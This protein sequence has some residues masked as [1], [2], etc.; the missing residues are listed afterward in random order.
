MKKYFLIVFLFLPLMAWSNES[1][2]YHFSFVDGG[3]TYIFG[4]NVRVRQAP[5]I[6]DNNI[7]ETLPAGYPVKII[8]KTDKHMAQNGFREYW[9]RIGFNKNG[10][11]M[12]GY[13]WGGVIAAGHINTGKDLFL[14][15]FKKYED[16][17]GFSG[18]CRLIR[19]GRIISTLPVMLHFIP[20]GEADPFY[21]YSISLKLNNNLGLAG[22]E[23]I[24]AIN[25]D[26]GACGYPHGNIWVGIAKGKL[27][28][29]GID[30]SV[31]EAGVFQYE[32]QMIFPAQDSTLKGE[33]RLVIENF[34]FDEKI[35]D[36]RLT[37]RKEKRYTWKNFKMEERKQ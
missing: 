28:Y 23:Q 33:V 2:V 25:N 35:N 26:Y 14:L 9:C 30:S 10:K 12:Q 13:A 7:I 36:Y 15:G 8:Q 29:L 34:E 20:S 19:N 22:L 6:K 27:Y 31:S 21:G 1:A 11:E 5:E 16:E 4:E 24:V 32:E 37:D 3:S 18:E 17:H